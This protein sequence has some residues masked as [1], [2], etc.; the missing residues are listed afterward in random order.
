M[1]T[2]NN[3]TF[4]KYNKNS[5]FIETGSY[6]GDGIYQA[7]YSGYDKIISIELSNKLYLHCKNR[8]INH[9]NVML[10]NGDSSDILGEL[11]ED[12]DVPVTFWLDG[13]YSS[14]MTQRGKLM[15]P[16]MEELDIIK[17]HHINNHTIL[18]DDMRCWKKEDPDYNFGE[19][20]IKDKIKQINKKYTIEYIDGFIPNDIL[21]ADIKTKL[22]KE[23]KL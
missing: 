11:L 10:Y 8:F 13:H 2:A 19:K 21:V 17:N 1:T 12:I 23:I 3:K 9:S 5:I 14:G 15:S 20:E 4:E 7:L 22:K 16:L 6:L 18:I